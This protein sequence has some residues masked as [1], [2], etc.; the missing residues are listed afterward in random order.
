MRNLMR[1]R[2]AA[3]KDRTRKRQE[4]RSFLLRHGKIYSGKQA[5]CTK[6]FRW[7]HR[8]RFR[9]TRPDSRAA[10]DDHSRDAVPGEGGTARSSDGRRPV[11]APQFQIGSS[12]PKPS[13]PTNDRR[14]PQGDGLFASWPLIET[15]GVEAAGTAEAG[16]TSD[17]NCAPDR[18][19]R[20]PSDRRRRLYPRSPGRRPADRGRPGGHPGINRCGSTQR[21]GPAA[22]TWSGPNIRVS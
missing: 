21:D 8:S 2:E 20:D 1:S 4:I 17:A 10:R 11:V 15:S 7:L 19:R 3:V 12:E 16:R 5:W 6:Y 18:L 22:C 14:N 13:P 9:L